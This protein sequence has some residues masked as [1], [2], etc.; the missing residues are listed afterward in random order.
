MIYADFESIIVPE[1]NR[2]QNP[3]KSYRKKYQKHIT[4]SYSCKLLCVADRVCKPF[5]WYHSS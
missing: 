2:K 5:K 1:D 4:C 3:N